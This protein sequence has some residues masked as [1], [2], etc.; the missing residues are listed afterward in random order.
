MISASSSKLN[1]FLWMDGGQASCY[2]DLSSHPNGKCVPCGIF[3]CM[4][5]RLR[6][7]DPSLK[8]KRFGKSVGNTAVK[9]RDND[10]TWPSAPEQGDC[11]EHSEQCQHKLA[12]AM[13][14]QPQW[15]GNPLDTA[16]Q[17]LDPDTAYCVGDRW[18][19]ALHACG[20]RPWCSVGL[21]TGGNWSTALGE[22][23][24]QG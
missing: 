23:L 5:V 8:G 2:A 7:Q 21:C 10:E 9:Y 11:R 13:R 14:S 17:L 16:S 6:E 4:D 3:C 15:C 24:L 18:G 12:P 1:R 19:A 20:L 22:P